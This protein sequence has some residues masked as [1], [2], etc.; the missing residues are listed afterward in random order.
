MVS[1]NNDS[2]YI[3]Y[4]FADKDLNVICEPKYDFYIIFENN[5]AVVQYGSTDYEDV[6]GL[7]NVH[8]GKYGV[9]MAIAFLISDYYPQAEHCI[10]EAF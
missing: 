10:F 1:Y 5:Y 8:N 3:G 7:G 9:N 2:E 4:G 6:K